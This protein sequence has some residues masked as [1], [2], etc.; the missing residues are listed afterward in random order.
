MSGSITPQGNGRL[1]WIAS[2]GSA[3]GATSDTTG[4]AIGSL[5]VILANT[6]TGFFQAGERSKVNGDDS[7]Y[8]PQ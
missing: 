8:T 5:Q 2:G 3:D 4:Y 6:G 1:E 7:Y